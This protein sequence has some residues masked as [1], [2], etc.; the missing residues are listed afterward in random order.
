MRWR[1]IEWGESSRGA[2]PCSASASTAEGDGA[3]HGHRIAYR[4][5]TLGE[6]VGERWRRA[7]L[8]HERQPRPSPLETRAH[9][10]GVADRRAYPG[11]GSLPSRRALSSNPLFG[12]FGDPVTISANATG[13]KGL[14]FRARR[15]ASYGSFNAL[16][17]FYPRTMRAP[18]YAEG[19]MSTRSRMTAMLPACSRRPAAPTRRSERRPSPASPRSAQLLRIAA[20]RRGARASLRTECAAPPSAPSANGTEDHAAG[21]GRLLAAS[22]SAIAPD[23]AHRDRPARRGPEQRPRP[24]SLAGSTGTRRKGSGRTRS[25]SCATCVR[26]RGRRLRPRWGHRPADRE[27]WKASGKRLRHAPRTSSYGLGTT[28][29]LRSP[30]WHERSPA[31]HRVSVGS[32]SDRRRVRA[33]RVDRSRGASGCANSRGGMRGAR[34]IARSGLSR[35]APSS[36]SETRSMA[37][38]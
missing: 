1:W 11:R 8:I 9:Q 18:L 35:G 12:T 21:G 16:V 7:E 3:Q 34:R 24:R 14:S 10:V 25:S 2:K 23:G 17:T 5:W 30:G 4:Q 33:R 19:R 13:D 6:L 28:P 31:P 22:A 38:A 27:R 32:R 37:S 20:G 15:A 26:G 36:D 29:C